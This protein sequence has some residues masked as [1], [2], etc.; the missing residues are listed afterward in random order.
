MAR[1]RNIKPGFFKNE[2]LAECSPWARLCFAGLWTLADREGRLEDRPKRIKGELFAFDSVETDPLLVELE[3]HG[4]IMRYEVENRGFIQII[5]FHKHQ[6]PHH[7]EPSSEIPSPQSLG[8]CQ[9][10]TDIKPEAFNPSSE[11]PS[12]QSL[13]KTETS[14]GLL[15]D[16]SSKHGGKTVL[17]PDSLLLIPESGFLIPEL[18]PSEAKASGAEPPPTDR[19]IV[20][21]TGVPLITAAGV[22]ESNARS[23]LAMLCKKHG[24]QAV[25]EAI[26]ETARSH[27][28]DPVSWL[29]AILKPKPTVQPRRTETTAPPAW[30][31]AR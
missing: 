2:D 31:G 28:G 13:V 15:V 23:M 11:I 19:E 26:T 10:G 9:H 17:N 18:I 14:P 12:P 5:A 6:N 27:A 22:K 21:A 20:F 30:E 16:E 25:V 8:L 7:K 29:Q 24:E 4:F 3:R 1:A